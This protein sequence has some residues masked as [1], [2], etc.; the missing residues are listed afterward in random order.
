MDGRGQRVPADLARRDRSGGGGRLIPDR[1][2]LPDRVRLADNGRR[3]Q[4]WSGRA[5]CATRRPAGV[6]PTGRRLALG[7]DPVDLTCDVLVGR[8]HLD[9]PRRQPRR[10]PA[11]S[12]RHRLRC[13]LLPDRLNLG[14]GRNGRCR[15]GNDGRRRGLGRRGNGRIGGLSGRSGEPVAGAAAADDRRP[16]HPVLG[17]DVPAPAADVEQRQLGGGRRGDRCC[18]GQRLPLRDGVVAPAVTVV[19]WD[20]R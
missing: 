4:C 9:H 3:P 16:R 13:G 8:G 20:V 18:R 2:H 12:G 17:P 7:N 5:S 11:W 6:L 1:R 19:T 14:G 15:C 10:V